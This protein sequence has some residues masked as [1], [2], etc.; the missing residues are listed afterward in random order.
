MGL[1]Y[2]ARNSDPA[3]L[4]II[5]NSERYKL[6]YDAAKQSVPP[7]CGK[8]VD[9]LVKTRNRIIGRRILVYGD[10]GGIGKSGAHCE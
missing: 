1:V 4:R 9:E 6:S 8:R 2:W 10:D 5:A 3:F 7:W